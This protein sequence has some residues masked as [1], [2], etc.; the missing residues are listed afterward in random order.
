[1]PFYRYV[2][3]L[4][5][6]GYKIQGITTELR[7]KHFEVSDDEVNSI[8]QDI[9]SIS[10]DTVLDCLTSRKPLDIDNP[11]HIDILDH[12]GITKYFLRNHNPSR[13]VESTP[14]WYKWVDRCEW[15][16]EHHD[17]QTVIHILLFNGDDYKSI[18][19]VIQFKYKYL[20]GEK[21]IETYVNTFWDVDQFSAKEAAK[22]YP[23]LKNSTYILRMFSDGEAEVE[24][25]SYVYPESMNS[26]GMGFTIMDSDYVKWKL[27]MRKDIRVPSTTDF[28]ENVKMDTMYKYKEAL[29]MTSSVESN[30]EEGEGFEGPINNSRT[31]RRNVEA[32]RAKLM[33]QYLDMFIKADG[34]IPVVEDAENESNFFENLQQVSLS[35][36]ED[37][38]ILSID[39]NREMLE[40]IKQDM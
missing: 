14:R 16:T 28:L 2:I 8:Y 13:T 7:R 15:I 34:A 21:S 11:A 25:V 20:L 38:K 40:D 24:H 6:S 32:E 39:D 5:F 29:H 3:Y 9:L 23:V 37:E 33:R 1:M 4:I 26:T 17:I 35:F 22:Y 30:K 18:A 36:M 10:S 27:G 12:F 31:I 19:A